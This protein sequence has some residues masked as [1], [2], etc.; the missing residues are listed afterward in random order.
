MIHSLKTWP[1]SFREIAFGQKTFELRR[2]D[3]RG[4]SIGDT[5]RLL[6]FIPGFSTGRPSHHGEFTGA[7]VDVRVM[8][9]S[10][11]TQWPAGIK[12]GFVIMS[13]VVE[14]PWHVWV[15]DESI[16]KTVIEGEKQ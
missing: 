13:I 7:F 14:A 6:E 4:F 12:D 16:T 5:L 11:A 2:N 3:D 9:I 15:D 1:E 8:T 10:T